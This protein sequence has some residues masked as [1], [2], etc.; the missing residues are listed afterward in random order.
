[1]DR[2]LNDRDAHPGRLRR[3][4]RAELEAFAAQVHRRKKGAIDEL[5]AGRLVGE[6]E[7]IEQ[8]RDPRHEDP[9]Q[10]EG[11][12]RVADVLL[13]QPARAIDDAQILSLRLAQEDGQ[14]RGVVL[15]VGILRD[16]IVAGRERQSGPY[17]GPFAPVPFVAGED[18]A[19]PI[20]LENRGGAVGRS[21]IDDDDFLLGPQIGREDPIEQRPHRALLVVDRNE[22]A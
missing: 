8:I 6:P 21:V 11:E 2:D 15:Q 5:V 3:H 18:D 4:F 12:G 13:P 17:R 20:R 7:P 22:D 14:V 9:A 16:G 1:V 19:I 10:I